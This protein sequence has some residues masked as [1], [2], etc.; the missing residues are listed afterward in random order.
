MTR[1]AS[2]LLRLQGKLK[3]LK[4]GK[5]HFEQVSLEKVKE[6][7]A[8]G[9]I[10]LLPSD[11]ATPIVENDEKESWMRLCEL[12]STEKDPEKLLTLVKEVNRMLDENKQPIVNPSRSGKDALFPASED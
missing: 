6:Q 2:D 9:E 7:I 4:G 1:M 3:S 12:A 10:S 5:M 8:S 11:D